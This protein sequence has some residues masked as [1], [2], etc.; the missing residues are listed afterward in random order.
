[1]MTL[2]YSRH[3]FRR[4]VWKSGQEVWARLHEEAFRYFGGCV[5]YVVR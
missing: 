3:S 4:V 2:R 5:Q 1:V